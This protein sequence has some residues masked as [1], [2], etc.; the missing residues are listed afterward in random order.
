MVGCTTTNDNNVKVVPSAVFKGDTRLLGLHMDIITGCV[1]VKYKGDKKSIV[2]DYE[3]WENGSLKDNGNAISSEVKNG[4]FNGE[5]SISLKKNKDNSMKMNTIIS[6][7]KEHTGI[8]KQID[9]FGNEFSHASRELEKTIEVTDNEKI[10]IWGLSANEGSK[11]RFG[12][13]DIESYIKS[14]SW[15]LLLKLYFK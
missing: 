3:I 6:K 14:D 7:D 4:K 1:E 5:V 13:D 15:G 12:S 9:G 10:V 11:I 8:G 2:V